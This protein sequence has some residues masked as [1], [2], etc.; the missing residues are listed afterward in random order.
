MMA[1]SSSNVLSSTGG[2]CFSFRARLKRCQSLLKWAR[3]AAA[4]GKAPP[5]VLH[6][7]EHGF[8]A[9]GPFVDG[10]GGF[11][12]AGGGGGGSVGLASHTAARSTTSTLPLLSVVFATA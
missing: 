12:C 4:S 11:A 3:C 5:Q 9:T 2:C 1:C 8:G 10:F 7:S 6:A